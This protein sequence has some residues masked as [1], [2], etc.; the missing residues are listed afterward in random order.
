MTWEE[1]KTREQT[2]QIQSKRTPIEFLKKDTVTF[3]EK[4]VKRTLDG[5]ETVWFKDKVPWWL[6][7]PI[8][9]SP[10]RRYSNFRISERRLED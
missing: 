6:L 5:G 3:V 2:K 10:R 1:I 8:Y 4:V 7:V 9:A